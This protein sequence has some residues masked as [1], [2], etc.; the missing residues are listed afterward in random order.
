MCGRYTV[1]V[2]GE[3][4][5]EEL[6]VG[7][8]PFDIRPRYNVAP[9]QL[10]P[11]VLRSRAGPLA[12][13][14][15]RWGLVPPWARDVTIGNR[16]INARAETLAT[17]PA[18]RSAFQRHRC[19]VAADG[20]YE[21]Q[22]HGSRKVPM[23]IHLRSR[24]PFAFA[25][26][27]ERW[28]PPEDPLHSF[29]IVTTA[30]APPI[31]D[32]HDRMPALLPPAARSTWLDPEADPVALAALLRPYPGDDLEA[33]AVSTLVNSPRNDLEACIEPLV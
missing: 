6:D 16:L 32:I 2:R 20:W 29:T 12:L 1:A 19:L 9:T 25:G 26:L 27:W 5:F 22:R 8:P 17:K 3:D 33:W 21:W 24:R 30:A 10:A 15:F 13:A 23:W 7:E 14:E 31:R 4:L 11:V 28:G 18:F